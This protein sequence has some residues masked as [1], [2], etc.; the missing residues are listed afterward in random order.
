MNSWIWKVVDYQKERQLQDQADTEFK[1][2]ASFFILSLSV[3]IPGIDF[4]RSAEN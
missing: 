1:I 2:L 3:K 4:N